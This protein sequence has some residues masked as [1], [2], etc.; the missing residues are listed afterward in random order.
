M[1][2]IEA[3]AVKTSS[4][5]SNLTMTTANTSQAQFYN[6]M[7]K[8]YMEVSTGLKSYS[9]AIIEAINEVSKQG[10]LVEY[11]SNRKINVES[12][13]RM[14]IVTGVNQTCGKL[15]LLRAHELGWDLM[16]L[17][18]HSGARHS[19]AE[20][21]G[22][23][24]SLSGQAGYLSLDNIGYGTA[25]GFKGINCRHDWRPYFKGST[26]TYTDKELERMANE[27]VIYNGQEISRYDAMQMQRKMERQIRQDKKG[28]AGL[29][30]ILT[31]T[32]KDD[33]LLDKARINL[34]NMKRVAK[35]HNLELNDF[36]AQAKFRKDYT[37]LQIG[38]IG[39]TK[40]VKNDIILT[41]KEQYAINKYIS[42]DF[43]K[44][45]EKLR[46]GKGLNS[47]EKELVTN[48]DNMLNKMPKYKGL[49]TRSLEL[50]KEQLQKFIN[51][52][53]L[54]GKIKYKA[55]TSTTCGERYNDISTVELYIDSINGRDI[56]KYNKEEQEILFKRSSLFKVKQIEKI[57]GTYHI[58]LEEVHG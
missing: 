30:G 37:R 19:H 27:K 44:I 24:V 38:K 31:S 8:A 13:V 2:L 23:I 42:S 32:T 22:R 26:R 49:V 54:G 4:N 11:P 10:A 18:A 40:D 35:Q 7:N 48:L 39:M 5:L 20:W 43:Y 34:D 28:I 50:D 3:T 55:Y 1:Q 58:L 51:I 56:R 12:A 17:T 6:A 25:T 57:K 21:Q 46:N 47:E 53:K 36:L 41:E 52:H 29:Q 16:E 33:E 45:N 14:N 9:Q 15:Q